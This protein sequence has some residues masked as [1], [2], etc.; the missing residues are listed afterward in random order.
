MIAD[1]II[2]KDGLPI[3]T[4]NLDA[5]AGITSDQ[6]KFTLIS[7]FLSAVSTFAD[8][9]EQLGH[10]QEIQMANDVFFH[11]KKVK[12]KGGELLFIATSNEDTPRTC[13][14]QLIEDVSEQFLCE[15]ESELSKGWN[16]SVGCFDRF[17]DI[18]DIIMQDV[19]AQIQLLKEQ[20]K[21]LPA[22][23][24]EFIPEM[25]A[26]PSEPSRNPEPAE[27]PTPPQPIK[28]PIQRSNS[29][30]EIAQAP[31]VSS[32]F[33]RYLMLQSEATRNQIPPEHLQ[34]TPSV[35]P[36]VQEESE[37]EWF[38]PHAWSTACDTQAPIEGQSVNIPATTQILRYA[39][40][41]QPIRTPAKYGENQG[42]QIVKHRGTRFVFS[43]PKPSPSSIA[44]PPLTMNQAPMNTYGMQNVANRM[45]RVSAY[46][47]I[48]CLRTQRLEN[49]DQVLGNSWFKA[50]YNAITG[51]C[52]VR[53]IA[54]K[55]RVSPPEILDACASMAQ[56][57][58][59]F[60]QE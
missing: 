60:F 39:P 15:F 7:G 56:A 16:G 42:T 35:A 22:T 41:P 37:C 5:Q 23:T 49:P 51:Y 50:I 1:L 10:I 59:I 29:P 12:L 9:V 6:T 36:P 32:R 45:F 30:G 44:Q 14:K 38:L 55:F 21:I 53:E 20:T 33:Q 48:P 57:G 4:K 3:Y 43:A 19:N 34:N 13:V 17:G 58:L 54:A 2:L 40:Q 25:N 28:R 27:P 47:K 11:F 18:F 46:E 26:A 8:S 52:S 24:P 31:V